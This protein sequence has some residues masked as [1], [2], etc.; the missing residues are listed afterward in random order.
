M[1]TT[2]KNELAF[3]DPLTREPLPGSP[4]V[5]L[6][7]RWALLVSDDRRHVLLRSY[8]ST[9]FQ[10]STV[11]TLDLRETRSFDEGVASVKGAVIS[12]PVGR[13]MM[14]VKDESPGS[15][16]AATKLGILNPLTGKTLVTRPIDGHVA[17]G[18]SRRAG[19]VV[20]IA[21]L[22]AESGEPSLLLVDW[23]GVARTISLP[24]FVPDFIPNGNEATVMLALASDERRLAVAS[25]RVLRVIDLTTGHSHSL[26]PPGAPVQQL[27]W[28][29]PGRVLVVTQRSATDPMR[30]VIVDVGSG[31]V[32]LIGESIWFA[33]PL[34]GNV[35]F[36]P[37]A[38]GVVTFASTGVQVG[39]A[40]A[41]EPLALS[42]SFPASLTP[43]VLLMPSTLDF[44]AGRRV[45]VDARTGAVVL[46]AE[47]DHAPCDITPIAGE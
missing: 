13:R 27:A 28:L 36:A 35:V 30:V 18:V 33:A 20:S 31:R 24:G 29:T 22:R 47:F 40:A 38:G 5:G 14:I 16:V 19:V 6:S 26:R 23:R 45:I 7:G 41:S 25:D 39:A 37:V 17:G 10:V 42:P 12:W 2:A 43:Y 21:P 4:T 46:D 34:A 11:E 9:P 15:P 32:R 1:G 44:K 8:Y 3:V